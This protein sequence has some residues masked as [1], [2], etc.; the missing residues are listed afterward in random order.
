MAETSSSLD[1]LAIAH[2][3]LNTNLEDPC[4]ISN[5][6]DTTFQI[7]DFLENNNFTIS[8]SQ[9]LAIWASLL[10]EVI[11]Q[12]N[13]APDCSNF[14]NCFVF[15][16]STV[17]KQNKQLSE[18]AEARNRFQYAYRYT[19]N[20]KLALRHSSISIPREI[21]AIFDQDISDKK[22]A[23][24]LLEQAI[25]YI[26][27]STLPQKIKNHAKSEIQ[28]IITQLQHEHTNWYIVNNKLILAIGLFGSLGSF[29]SGS[30]A[31]INILNKLQ[32][33]QQTIIE[34]SIN[35]D[36]FKTIPTEIYK[37]SLQNKAI[38][39]TTQDPDKQK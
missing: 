33:A 20:L 7:L 11:T 38:T 13:L 5:L 6:I 9:S 21:K 12:N 23:I 24:S 14:I 25:N 30:D 28:K 15:L 39:A 18:E 8:Q 16:S 3:F 10:E 17:M 19:A 32:S 37:L 27:N 2:H 35:Q 26:E 29:L 4:E 31:T 22:R 34:T 36:F 1:L